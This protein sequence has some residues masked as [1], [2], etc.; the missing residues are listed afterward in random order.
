MASIFTQIVNG[1]I[2]CYKIAENDEFLAFLD[3]NPNSVGHTLCIPKREV[4][5]V[6]DLEAPEFTKLMLFSR[7][8]AMAI[9][10]AV[11]CN[12]VGLSVIGLEVPHTHVHLIPLNTMDDARF[13]N[14][15]TMT[16]EDFINTA[17]QIKAFL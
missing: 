5:K 12:R 14:K 4:D 8:I 9:E 15:V 3:V 13:I 7:K 10:Q 2:P 1:E 16:P 6:F 11:P 17:N